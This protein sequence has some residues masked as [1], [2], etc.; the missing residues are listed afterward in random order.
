V[1][2]PRRAAAAALALVVLGGCAAAKG[3]PP[4]G[5]SELL[6]ESSLILVT[7][8]PGGEEREAAVADQLQRLFGVR[9]SASWHM[10]SL[11]EQC[12]VMVAPPWLTA[13]RAAAE[14]RNH[15]AVSGAVAVRRF[16]V[17]G[18]VGTD[19]YLQLQ[20]ESFE[21]P[22]GE[23]HAAS[24]GRGVTIAVVDTGLDFTHPDL[25]GRVTRAVDFVG[26]SRGRFNGDFHGTAVAGVIAA[27]GGNGIGGVGVAP[28]ARLWALRACWQS[29][30]GGPGA[31]CDTYTLA[32]ALDL[33]A[34][35]TPRVL[36]LSLA[37]ERDEL[38]ERLVAAAIA[39]G[40]VVV[41]AAAGGGPSFPASVRGVLAVH[42]AERGRPS[43]APA[44]RN[45]GTLAAPGVD[46]LTTVPGGSFD[47][48]SGSSFAAAWTSGVVAL[49]LERQPDIAPRSVAEL[50]S[51]TATRTPRDA[52][53]EPCAALAR[54]T[55]AAVCAP[56]AGA[57]APRV[58]ATE[59]VP[60][61]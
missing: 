2:G 19:P 15:P 52:R 27:V 58:A 57:L 42:A 36:N 30:A 34:S 37:G 1:S 7:L 45:D 39:R 20:L 56:G 61:P 51:M 33:V 59:E 25:A 53:V 22:L 48:V 46:L 31:V 16:E 13:E 29:P 38:I 5:A 35:E 54:L 26:R 17:L 8:R 43:P 10:R 40:V 32:Q 44:A 6:A 60:P 24:T 49:V 23:L 12:L 41:A 28:D 4:A 3:R 11:G 50:L 21:L 14:V 18:G 47:F 9:L 55:D